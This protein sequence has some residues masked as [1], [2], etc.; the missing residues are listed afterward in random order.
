MVFTI[1]IGTAV[2]LVIANVLISFVEPKNTYNTQHKNWEATQVSIVP[3]VIHQV[4]EK[5]V[6]EKEFLNFG[7]V[8]ANEQKINLIN[9][10]LTYLEK[11]LT[12]IGQK[13]LSLENSDAM[14][15]EKIDF[16]IKLL[17]QEIE[18]IKNPKE[19]PKTFYGQTN[20]PMEATIKSLVFNS[21]RKK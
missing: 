2:V 8:I 14:D 21:A 11:A 6:D 3:E 1:L 17:E 4:E 13:E 5:K 7:K 19:K 20:D 16:K 15:Y 9:Q 12:Q 18:E 10:R